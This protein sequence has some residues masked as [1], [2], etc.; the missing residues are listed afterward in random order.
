MVAGQIGQDFAVQ[1]DL[2]FLEAV[3][4]PAVRDALLS[5]GGVDLD[6]PERPQVPLFHFS[7]PVGIFP[8]VVQRVFGRPVFAFSAPAK[9]LGMLQEMLSA[10]VAG[11]ASF[12]SGHNV[13]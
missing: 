4:K 10:L 12:N 6:L 5:A 7:V 9:T 13:L 11:F 3:N 2:V 1:F 8:G